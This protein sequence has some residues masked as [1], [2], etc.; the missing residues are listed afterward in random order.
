M[1]APQSAWCT[2]SEKT[3]GGSNRSN[4]F[5]LMNWNMKWNDRNLAQFSLVEQN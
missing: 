1:R 2:A 3:W 4:N 5:S